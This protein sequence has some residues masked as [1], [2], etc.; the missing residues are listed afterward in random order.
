MKSFMT[1]VELSIEYRMP[2]RLSSR[3]MSKERESWIRNEELS[4]AHVRWVSPFNI[5]QERGISRRWNDIYDNPIEKYFL[6]NCRFTDGTN[7]RVSLHYTGTTATHV[8]GW[9]LHVALRR[10]FCSLVSNRTYIEYWSMI[11]ILLHGG[12]NFNL[13]MKIRTRDAKYLWNTE[14]KA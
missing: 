10:V 12:L 2:F 5:S 13:R 1:R 9:S 8:H 3:S 6:R 14:G 7:Q 4:L 11:S